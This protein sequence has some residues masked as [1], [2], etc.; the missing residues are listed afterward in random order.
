[1]HF[2]LAWCASKKDIHGERALCTS[3]LASGI[4]ALLFALFSVAGAEAGGVVGT[5]SPATCTEAALDA[6]LAGGGSVTFDCGA[7]PATIVLTSQKNITLTTTIDGGGKI[8]LSGNDSTRLLDV[9]SASLSLSNLTLSHGSAD[10]GGAIYNFLGVVTI[11]NSTLSSNSAIGSAYPYYSIG[12]AIY[13]NGKVTITGSTFSGNWST[14]I[15][16]AVSNSANATIA[17]STFYSNS[18]PIAGG[19][20]N[21]M[22]SSLIVTG[23]TFTNNSATAGDGG[24]IYNFGTLTITT[25]TL[26]SNTATRSGGIHN[27]G[28]LAVDAVTFSGNATPGGTGGGVG[29]DST[30]ALTITNSTFTNN[31]G[32]TAGGGIIASGPVSVTNS[33]I[34]SNAASVGGGIASGGSPFLLKNTI[35]ANN[36]PANCTYGTITSTGHNLESANDCGLA[37]SGDITNTAPFLGALANNGGPTQTHALLPGSPAI[38][39]GDNSGCPATDQRGGARPR[40]AQN[41]CDI[42]AYEAEYLFLPLIKR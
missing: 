11:V 22:D 42:G 27:S 32:G 2:Q 14:Y 19:I 16:G 17:T 30:G 24:G 6:A 40:T 9:D 10:G 26:S 5:G 41:P 33:T 15:G 28:N 13:S 12:G 35:V 25:S 29:N 39:A 31:F 7:G 38:N 8:T 37:A 36:T 34:Y 3:L 21:G 18:A 4:T 23:S 20:V 1:M